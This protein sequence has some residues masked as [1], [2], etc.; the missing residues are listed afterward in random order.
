M[1]KRKQLK[2]LKRYELLM[3]LDTA[4]REGAEKEIIERVQKEIQQ[5]GGRIEAV[6][7]LGLK[8]FARTT[9]RRSAGYY[10]NFVFAAPGKAIAELNAKFHLDTDLFR[11]QF[12][13][14]LAQ[15]SRR[16][17]KQESRQPVAKSEHA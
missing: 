10:V 17:P 13:E 4:E 7:K 15:P 5:A 12:T 11:W 14:V 8:Q 6:Q 2:H 3:I 1:K 16:E 9:R